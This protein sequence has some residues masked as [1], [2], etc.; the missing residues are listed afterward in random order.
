MLPAS[1]LEAAD[2]LCKHCWISSAC[3]CCCCCTVLQVLEYAD[4][5][6]AEVLRAYCLAVAICNLDAVL[7]EAGGAF[8]ELAPHLLS[9]MERIYKLRLAGTGASSAPAAAAEAPG[10]STSEAAGS[11]VA[12][13]A[14]PL[15]QLGSRLQP[16]RRPTAAAPRL[17]DEGVGEEAEGHR[18]QGFALPPLVRGGSSG[19]S[20]LDR[21][22]ADAAAAVERLRRMLNKKV[23]QIE[24]LEARA[25]E[26][27]ALDPQQRSKVH[28]KPVILS[29]LAALEGGMAVDDVQRI[30]RA[31][32]GSQEAEEPAAAG[33]GSSGARAAAPSSSGKPPKSKGKKSGAQKAAPPADEPSSSSPTAMAVGAAMAASSSLLGSSPP[34]SSLVPAFGAAGSAAAAAEQPRTPA[35]QM[36]S[37]VGFA[38]SNATD[39]VGAAPQQLSPQQQLEQQPVLGRPSSTVKTK[40][41]AK[42]KGE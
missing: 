41:A 13:A 34:T 38:S 27:A 35:G 22:Q 3:I 16:G 40:S 2:V 5:A 26:G 21:Q 4:V 36:R 8:E 15:P 24:Q 30:L 33:P 37:L 12:R 14:A 29:A 1:E 18:P 42:R 7:L 9:E 11:C 25:E 17:G 39:G 31:A 10:P 20:F 23:Q 19:S 6:G 28:Q 32:A